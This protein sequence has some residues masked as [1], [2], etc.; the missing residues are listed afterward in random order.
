MSFSFGAR[1]LNRAQAPALVLSGLE[2]PSD[3]YIIDPTLP[4]IGRDVNIPNLDEIVIAR[5]RLLSVK[6][7]S[8]VANAPYA[9]ESRPVVTLANGA[10]GRRLAGIGS[11]LRPM[12]FAETQYFRQYSEYVQPDPQV[13]KQKLVSLP[14][15]TG[16]NGVYG[17]IRP[18]DYVTASFGTA[19]GNS[20]IAQEVGKVVKWVPRRLINAHQ[21]TA[22]TLITLTGALYPAFVPNIISASN[23]GAYA[24]PA[25]VTVA[26]NVS[27][28][29]WQATFSTA[30]SDVWFDYGQDVDNRAGQCASFE[31][32]GNAGGQLNHNHRFAGWLDWVRDD[33]S[34][35][36]YPPLLTPRPY[37][38]ITAETPNALGSNQYQ[39]AVT[40]IV[41]GNTITVSVTGTRVDP[42]SGTSTTLT[43]NILPLADSTYYQDYTQG[44][45]YDIN[46]ITG[47]LTIFSNVTVSSLTV[48]YSAETSF[49]DGKL[50]NPG[51]IGLTDGRFSG[52]P[53]TPANLELAGVVADMHVFL[54]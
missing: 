24:N 38:T 21:G 36:A 3:G 32:V 13:T 53:G 22:A 26:Y 48:T 8:V 12:G 16:S 52:Q 10:D 4:V 7:S 6:D 35:W 47:V 29:V 51:Q 11:D 44:L 54:F 27:S 30:V 2:A 50:Y 15:I 40:P 46:F 14:Y 20:V 19:N 41:P 49:L 34:M 18:G 17:N 31:A 45:D 33:Y 42:N 43:N 28:N 37:T 25:G 1:S 5:G 39:L 23:A 9:N